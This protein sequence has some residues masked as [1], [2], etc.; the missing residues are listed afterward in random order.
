MCCW[1]CCVLSSRNILPLCDLSCISC[2]ISSLPLVYLCSA[3][4]TLYTQP[5][6]TDFIFSVIIA[7][8]HTLIRLIFFVFSLSP[9][10]LCFHIYMHYI[11]IYIR[12]STL[13]F[14]FHTLKAFHLIRMCLRVCVYVCICMF[15]PDF[16]QKCSMCELKFD[17]ISYPAILF[18]S[19]TTCEC[20]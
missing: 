7:S 1:C 13:V 6:P 2:V 19:R 14:G 10:L 20:A 8:V 11:R 3:L 15:F 9:L 5:S 17:F 12:I 18:A 4:Y 16:T